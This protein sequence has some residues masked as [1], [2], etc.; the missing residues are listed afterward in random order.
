MS[1][2]VSV[3]TVTKCREA[4]RVARVLGVRRARGSRRRDAVFTSRDGDLGCQRC[5]ECSLSPAL[6]IQQATPSDVF[7]MDQHLI[8][9]RA[10]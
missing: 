2:G 9:V 8:H 10:A 6:E 5:S 4:S 3:P 7:G 1:L